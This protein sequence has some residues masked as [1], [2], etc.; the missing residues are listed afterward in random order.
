MKKCSDDAGYYFRCE[1]HCVYIQQTKGIS[2]KASSAKKESIS[3]LDSIDKIFPEISRNIKDYENKIFSKASMQ[4]VLT[5]KVVPEK[6]AS[7]MIYDLWLDITD[8]SKVVSPQ[9]E[10]VCIAITLQ[11]LNTKFKRVR[12]T[13]QNASKDVLHE[14][15]LNRWLFDYIS[16]CLSKLDYV[17][18]SRRDNVRGVGEGFFPEDITEYATSRG[19]LVIYKCTGLQEIRGCLVHF[20][21]SSEIKH[22]AYLRGMVAELKVEDTSSAPMWECFHNMSA[23]GAALTMRVLKEGNI[24]DKVCMYGVI[25]VVSCLEQSKLLYLEMNYKTGQ[26]H[27]KECVNL[28]DFDILMNIVVSFL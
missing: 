16:S 21:G 24:V 15:Q 25:G 4:L 9:G 28:M 26:C 13:I 3:Q 2:K 20:A 14:L 6:L 27:F 8:T 12:E 19:D 7:D 11:D 18:E 23:V 22:V 5:S 1:S 17:V 10:E